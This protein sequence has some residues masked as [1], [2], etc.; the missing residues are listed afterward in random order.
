MCEKK[1]VVAFDFDGTLTSRDTLLEF[2]AFSKGP[3]VL[4]GTFLFFSPLLL[5]YKAGLYPNWKIKEKIFSYLYKGMSITDFDAH[6]EAFFE[7]RGR[8]LIRA[9]AWRAVRE[10]LRAGHE[11]LILTASIVN[12]VRPF[13]RALGIGRVE[14]TRIEVSDEG[15]ITGRFLSQNCY[16]AEKVARLRALFPDRGRYYLTAYGDSRGDRELLRYADEG[17]LRAFE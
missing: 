3:A 4:Y 5:L 7:S 15:H 6:C 10:H 9:K 12:W 16:G 2:I 11:T 17:R 14:G 8:A 1:V 13:G